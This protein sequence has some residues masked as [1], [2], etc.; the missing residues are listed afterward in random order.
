MRV[1]MTL[2]LIRRDCQLTRPVR[3]PSN[4]QALKRALGGET[5]KSRRHERE[6]AERGNL[7]CRAAGERGPAPRRDGG[8]GETEGVSPGAISKREM[9]PEKSGAGVAWSLGGFL[10]ARLFLR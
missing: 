6:S 8:P 3:T 5:A 2:C 9:A 1:G 10:L 7:S 4:F